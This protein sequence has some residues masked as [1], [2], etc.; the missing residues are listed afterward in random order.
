[1]KIKLT[2]KQIKSPDQF[3]ATTT[4]IYNFVKPY[5]QKYNNHITIGLIVIIGIFVGAYFLREYKAKKN[6]HASAI[7]SEAIEIYN[8]EI[9]PDLKDN[10]KK[11]TSK[12]EKF[13]EAIK[14]L[15]EVI[16]KY[17][18]TEASNYS[19]LFLGNS[20]YELEKYDDAINHYK[21]FHDRIK[22]NSDIKL[23]AL[24]SLGHSYEA[25]GDIDNAIDYYSKILK[26]K[27][28]YLSDV[29]YYNLGRCYEIK[30]DTQKSKEYYDKLKKEFPESRYTSLIANKLNTL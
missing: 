6:T 4:K 11:F 10:N 23:L 1:L 2:R 14:K 3:I 25:K 24:D 22:K 17:P 27:N 12:D 18:K 15:K 21:I 30:S 13:N 28:N 29:T 19:Y 20:Y 16:N 8:S 9:N 26:I 5:F 7:L